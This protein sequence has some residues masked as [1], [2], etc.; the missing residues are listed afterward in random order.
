MA[1]CSPGELP[2]TGWS[3]GK[4]K[5]FSGA[6]DVRRAVSTA[7]LSER[8][9]AL[10]IVGAGIGSPERR[11]LISSLIVC[12]ADQLR[13]SSGG[14]LRPALATISQRFPGD[15]WDEG[16][17]SHSVSD[18]TGVERLEWDGRIAEF[19]DVTTP[20]LAGPGMRASR[21]SGSLGNLEAAAQRAARVVLSGEGG[22]ELGASWGL[23]DDL[24]ADRP[25]L[26][27]VETILRHDFSLSGRRA[28][29][30]RLLHHLVPD[31]LRRSVGKL[32]YHRQLPRWLQPRWRRR[33][34]EMIFAPRTTDAGPSFEHWVQRAHWHEMTCGRTATAVICS[35]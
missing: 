15:A 5:H 12:V 30:R 32:G 35:N 22:D 18:W 28:R 21:S 27:A 6:A 20:S 8:R 16:E 23:I 25:F 34:L 29:A 33:A 2:G 14:E 26:F 17:F 9:S 24:I 31:S 11:S 19:L 10:R 4:P 13:R 7:F 3:E 1:R